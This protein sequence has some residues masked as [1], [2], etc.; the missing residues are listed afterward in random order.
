LR[1]QLMP[2]LR[3]VKQGERL[4]L[5]ISRPERGKFVVTTQP[6]P[7][8]ADDGAHKI[9]EF[10][11]KFANGVVDLAVVFPRLCNEELAAIPKIANA[12]KAKGIKPV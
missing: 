2:A 8:D 9:K 10:L 4:L 12:L 6:L 3:R 5:T 1:P 11:D 7:P